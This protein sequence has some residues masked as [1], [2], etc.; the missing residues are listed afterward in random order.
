MIRF[1]MLRHA[2]LDNTINIAMTLR[3]EKQIPLR[4]YSLEVFSMREQQQ[5]Q[6]HN[7]KTTAVFASPASASARQWH[8]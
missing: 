1:A 6:Q 7:L 4:G 8:F 5:P 3:L 2:K